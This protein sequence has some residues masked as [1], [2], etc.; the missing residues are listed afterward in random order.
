[1]HSNVKTISMQKTKDT[2]HICTNISLQ[3]I[4]KLEHPYQEHQPTFV[5]SPSLCSSTK[6]YFRLS[7]HL[8]HRMITDAYL[9]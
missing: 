6:G 9:Y 1:M 8:D 3:I 5:L 2:M 4:T 7:K